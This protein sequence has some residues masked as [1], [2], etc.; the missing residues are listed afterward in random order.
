MNPSVD[1][2][3]LRDIHLPETVS[4]WPP[5][6]GWWLLALLLILLLAMP[7]L[8]RRLLP[9]LRK[10][11]RRRP[12]RK[13]ALGEWQRIRQAY[14]EHGD[15]QRLAQDISILL[16]RSAISSVPRQQVA[17][18][19][20]DAWIEQLDRLSDGGGFSDSLGQQLLTAP[21]RKHAD[22]DAD[23]LLERSR[24]WLQGL[25]GRAQP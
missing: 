16:R 2:L 23:A 12:L 8:I 6:P 5:G 15:R 11:W 24:Q 13:Q 14:A 7:W 18:L 1:P 25:A 9:W 22:I 4:W 17:S 19:T 20:G 3:P 10:K 21:Y